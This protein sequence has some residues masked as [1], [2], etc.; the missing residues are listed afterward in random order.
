LEF[1][2]FVL[3]GDKEDLIKRLQ[4]VLFGD[5]GGNLGVEKAKEI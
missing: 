5:Q 3:T 2:P 1:K 4:R